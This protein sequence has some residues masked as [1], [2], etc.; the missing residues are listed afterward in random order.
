[1]KAHV[2]LVFFFIFMLMNT[3]K[4]LRS[5]FLKGGRLLLRKFNKKKEVSY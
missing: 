2:N 5:F 1:M 4:E 3:E